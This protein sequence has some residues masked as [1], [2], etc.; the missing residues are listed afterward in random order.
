MGTCTTDSD[1]TS[2]CNPPSGDVAC[3]DG[4][5]KQCYIASGVCMSSPTP[6]D[7]SGVTSGY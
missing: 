3:C 6:T 4:M 2:V 5:T 7:D 1:C